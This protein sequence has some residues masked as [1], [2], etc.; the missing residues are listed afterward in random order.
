MGLGE[1]KS[2]DEI[3]EERIEEIDKQL[4]KFDP[5][6][7]I[8]SKNIAGTCKENLLESLSITNTLALVT[9]HSHA[10]Q[11]HSSL[12]TSQVPLS[13]LPDRNNRTIVKEA[14]WKRICRTYMGADTIMED[15]VGEK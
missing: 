9:Q 12:P 10:H 4:S 3:F 14:T 8:A 11:P 6:T 13:V 2:S 1:R 5:N 15:S 7:D